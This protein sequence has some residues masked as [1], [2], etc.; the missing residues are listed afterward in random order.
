[1]KFLRLK[2][3][4]SKEYEKG[5]KRGLEEF[6]PSAINK[7]QFLDDSTYSNEFIKGYWDGFEKAYNE[8]YEKKASVQQ[9]NKPKPTTTLP[10]N[11]EW[12]WD[13]NAADWVAVMKNNTNVTPP[14]YNPQ[15]QNMVN[16]NAT[17]Y[18]STVKSSSN[19]ALSTLPRLLDKCWYDYDEPTAGRYAQIGDWEIGLGGYDM[20]YAISYKGTPIFSIDEDNEV[21]PFLSDEK[22]QEDFGFSYSDV[23]KALKKHR[24]LENLK[25]INASQK[26][27]E[28]VADSIINTYSG[29]EEL[30]GL[31]EYSRNEKTRKEL[32]SLFQRACLIG[33]HKIL[34]REMEEGSTMSCFPLVLA[35]PYKDVKQCMQEFV[36]NMNVPTRVGF[37]CPFSNITFIC[38]S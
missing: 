32:F 20:G 31:K 14:L 12:S 8:F 13:P 29:E 4:E 1:M 19:I 37:Q 22:L 21:R 35:R 26:D 33:R 16:T 30:E 6:S 34:V 11:M 23:E 17:T 28:E 7:L 18:M 3:A 27:I 5:F 38:F 36:Y 2:K 9:P 10:D 15:N 24:D 25:M